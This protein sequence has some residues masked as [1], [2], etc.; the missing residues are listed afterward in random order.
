MIFDKGEI[1]AVGIEVKSK[2]G[3]QF[4]IDT[5]EYVV[6]LQS[7]MQ[8]RGQCGIDGHRLTMLFHADNVGLHK[9]L[10]TYTIADEKL[11]DEVL[12]EVV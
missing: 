10:F 2:S 12:V 4:V 7:E 6:S 5:A 3:D 1:R 9:I 11:I 8:E